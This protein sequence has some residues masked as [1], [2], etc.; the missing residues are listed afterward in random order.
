MT[1]QPQARIWAVARDLE[2]T[3]QQ[4]TRYYLALEDKGQR[5][6]VELILGPGKAMSVE[7]FVPRDFDYTIHDFCQHDED[8]CVLEDEESQE[9]EDDWLAQMH[10]ADLARTP[11]SEARS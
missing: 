1:D 3:N 9:Y 5:T 4:R 2:G 8:Y 10:S 7:P 6:D 11:E